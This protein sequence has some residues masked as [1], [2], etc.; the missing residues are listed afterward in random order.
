MTKVR[1]KILRAIYISFF[2]L[3]VFACPEIP[4]MNCVDLGTKLEKDVYQH[5][6]NVH[7]I[8]A[9]FLKQVS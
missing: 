8:A 5:L 1:N 9:I 6:S 4:I 3:T 2:V 7:Q